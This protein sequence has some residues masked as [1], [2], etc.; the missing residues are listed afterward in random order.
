M[1]ACSWHNEQKGVT[2]MKRSTLTTGVLFILFLLGFLAVAEPRWKPPAS[3]R[4]ANPRALDRTDADRIAD[5]ARGER[6]AMDAFRDAVAAVVRGHSRGQA[7]L[8]RWDQCAQPVVVYRGGFFG[9][10]TR[11]RDCRSPF[12]VGFVHPET[13]DLFGA[14]L[15]DGQLWARYD[16]TRRIMVVDLS[17]PLSTP[18]LGFVGAHELLHVDEGTRTPDELPL[19]EVKAYDLEIDLINRWTRGTFFDLLDAES[20]LTPL[21]ETRLDALF[22][23]AAS[24]DEIELRHLVYRLAHRFRMAERNSGGNVE[25][26]KARAFADFVEANVW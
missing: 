20:T 22:P 26:A 23:P 15:L 24:R 3:G 4:P 2:A 21:D 17:T 18:W 14:F 11:T 1:L 19:H 7:L 8:A 13:Q 25:R 9:P 5:L 6:P 10:Q 16:P 12:G